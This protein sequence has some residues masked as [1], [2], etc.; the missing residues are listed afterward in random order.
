MSGADELR[1][2]SQDLGKIASK[3]LPETEKVL[4]KGALNIKNDLIQGIPSGS[5]WRALRGAISYDPKPAVGSV[6]FEVGPDKGRR[7]GAL[8]N[9]Y[10]FGGS[11]GGGYG[12]L[13]G[14]LAREAPNVERELNKLADR[15]GDS[16]G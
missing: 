11:R 14:P 13:E 3:A 16:L 7:G 8:G 4:E 2:F 6:A 15:W 12:D 9:L 1:K 5:S 10:Y